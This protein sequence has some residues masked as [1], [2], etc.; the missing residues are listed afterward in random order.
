MLSLALPLPSH[1]S[2]QQLSPHTVSDLLSPTPANATK[3]IEGE[4]EELCT[5]HH[6][7]EFTH[8][9]HASTLYL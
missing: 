4:M 8:C 3:E 6:I 1:P 7:A 2:P 5:A 9:L